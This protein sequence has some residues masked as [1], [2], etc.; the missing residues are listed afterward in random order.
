MLARFA[1]FIADEPARP[2][3]APRTRAGGEASGAI[4]LDFTYL[5]G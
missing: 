1:A 3:P 2:S 4:S 5:T